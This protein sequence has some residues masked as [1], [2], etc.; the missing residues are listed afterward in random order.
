M[1][2]P[3]DPERPVE[4]REPK[5]VLVCDVCGEELFAGD[6]YYELP[7]FSLTNR[8]CENCAAAWLEKRRR[9]AEVGRV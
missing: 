4:P 8:V 5:A 3:R 2:Y 6:D 9:A 7:V 1:V